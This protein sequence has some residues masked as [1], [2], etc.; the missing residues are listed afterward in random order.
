MKVGAAQRRL[1][2]SRFLLPEYENYDFTEKA[3]CTG[4]ISCAKRFFVLFSCGAESARRP[5]TKY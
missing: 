1:C 3:L 5:L 4:W 2:R